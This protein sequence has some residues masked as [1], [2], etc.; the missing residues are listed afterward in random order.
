MYLSLLSILRVRLCMQISVAQ[1][2]LFIFTS[3]AVIAQNIL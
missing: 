2:D 3:G 1:T